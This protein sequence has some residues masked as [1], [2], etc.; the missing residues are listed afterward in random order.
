MKNIMFI[1][2][3][4]IG[5]AFANANPAN[6]LSGEKAFASYTNVQPGVWR[7]ITVADL[8]KPAPRGI[9]P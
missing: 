2:V 8:P 4:A 1:G 6:V 9:R 3:A 7:H 5:M